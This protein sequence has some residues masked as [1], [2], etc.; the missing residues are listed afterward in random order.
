MMLLGAA[1]MVL[2][3]VLLFAVPTPAVAVGTQL[4]HGLM[5]M[6]IVMAP[7]VFLNRHAGDGFRNSMQGVYA[8][9]V[10]GTGRVVGNYLAGAIAARFAVTG[11]FAWSAIL[12]ALA[13]ALIWVAFYE[14]E[15]PAAAAVPTAA[16]T[17]V[18]NSPGQAIARPTSNA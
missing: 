6:V 7:P 4:L 13:L 2:R 17:P 8:L 9:L 18:D 16:P 14:E 3:F 1:A 10:V 12:C 15:H 5:V 11:V